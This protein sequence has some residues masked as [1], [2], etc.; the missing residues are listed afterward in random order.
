MHGRAKKP[1][2]GTV[3]VLLWGLWQQ[4]RIS[5]KKWFW[6][7]CGRR[8]HRGGRNQ[9]LTYKQLTRQRR[10]SIKK[11]FRSGCERRQDRGCRNPQ[12]THFTFDWAGIFAFGRLCQLLPLRFLL[13]FGDEGE[14]ERQ[15]LWFKKQVDP[16]ESC[17]HRTKQRGDLDQL[18][19]LTSEEFEFH[20]TRDSAFNQ[21]GGQ[22]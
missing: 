12:F 11:W 10:I 4:R 8:R 13:L 5:N 20:Q 14:E 7:E 9:Q 3:S 21:N 22:R 16:F 17:T 2:E 19:Q 1:Q 6:P 18:K 15:D